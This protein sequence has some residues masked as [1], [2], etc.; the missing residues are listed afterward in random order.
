VLGVQV[1]EFGAVVAPA[2]RVAADSA[3]ESAASTVAS[4]GPGQD[5]ALIDAPFGEVRGEYLAEELV[6]RDAE[7]IASFSSGRTEGMPALT[8]RRA[9][10][11]RG[12]Y[13]ATIPDDAGMLA[14]TRWAVEL[15]GAR[16]ILP[17][18]PENVEVARRGN[19]VTIINHG[20]GEATVTITG[21]DLVTGE[22]ASTI[23]LPPFGWALIREDE[24]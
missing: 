2:A 8:S 5:H 6:V 4:S 14:V 13:L 24:K 3:G 18:L 15:A 22:R 16:P 20:Q 23:S 1:L 9:G 12:H 21:T 17:G 11:G 7:V 10:T 19:V